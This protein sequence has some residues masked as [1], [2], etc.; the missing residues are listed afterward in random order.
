MP[1]YPDH[2]FAR[3]MLQSILKWFADAEYPRANFVI[4]TDVN[5]LPDA[6]QK[7]EDDFGHV[8]MNMSWQATRDMEFSDDGVSFGC[9]SQG[10]HYDV[11][12]EYQD[13]VG[14]F[15]DKG[16]VLFPYIP[17]F[18]EEEEEQPFD[19]T[20][21]AAMDMSYRPQMQPLKLGDKE[22]D[23]IRKETTDTLKLI[24]NQRRRDHLRLVQNRDTPLIHEPVDPKN[25]SYPFPI[26]RFADYN[27]KHKE[28][29]VVQNPQ[30]DVI[31][32]GT[33]SGI[34]FHSRKK[35]PRQRPSW[36]TVLDGGQA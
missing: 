26:D 23:A 36:L 20:G 21:N 27:D 10:K 8:T 5:K 9:M 16:M 13:I 4:N 12:I 25:P 18:D 30:K 17:H 35:A 7:Q 3:S 34:D 29:E 33:P 15:T 19:A 32:N 14:F 1:V 24:Q 31:F 28:R 22:K 2:H 6:F 11:F